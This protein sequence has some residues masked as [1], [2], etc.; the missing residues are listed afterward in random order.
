MDL[1]DI[2]LSLLGLSEVVFLVEYA[3]WLSDIDI[4]NSITPHWL[5]FWEELLKTW[6]VRA[7]VLLVTVIGIE[8][9]CSREK[10]K[11]R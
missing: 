10:K 5:T 6:S 3:R 8:M 2:S 7:T 9:S 4:P 1:I 11:F